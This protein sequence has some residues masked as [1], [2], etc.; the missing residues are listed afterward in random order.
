MSKML[1]V[2]AVVTVVVGMFVAVFMSCGCG[3][4]GLLLLASVVM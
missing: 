3:C 4:G 2:F 1:V